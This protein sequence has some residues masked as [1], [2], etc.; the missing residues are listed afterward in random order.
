LRKRLLAAAALLIAGLPFAA[1]AGGNVSVGIVIGASDGG[2][3]R[4]G[5][6]ERD[7]EY[8]LIRQGYEIDH[9]DRRGEAFFVRV[10]L[11]FDIFEGYID[12]YNGRW[13][14][15]SRVG[16]WNGGRDWNRGGYRKGDWD[17]EREWRRDRDRD[18]DWDRR[19]SRDRD[20]DRREGR[21]D[22]DRRRD[23]DSEGRRGR[24]RDR[25][26]DGRW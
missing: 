3:Y 24:G 19:R 16:Y 7:I 22:W 12:C 13:L 10:I 2:Y 17:R 15:R 23:R 5:Y 6:S 9:I 21:G 1:Q 25:D 11:G 8:L 20:W 4:G 14:Q 26:R 18:R